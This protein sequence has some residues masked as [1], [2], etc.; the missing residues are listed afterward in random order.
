M[1]HET[2][3]TICITTFWSIAIISV[4]GCEVVSRRSA[5]VEKH[6]TLLSDITKLAVENSKLAQERC[7]ENRTE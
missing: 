7:E 1:S 2:I 5:A 6:N 3:K 4:A